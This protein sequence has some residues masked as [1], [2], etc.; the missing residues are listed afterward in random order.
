MM[1]KIMKFISSSADKIMKLFF[2][3]KDKIM[4]LYA[5]NK[6]KIMELVSSMYFKIAAGILCVL[7]VV[8][9]VCCSGGKKAEEE[10]PTEP[11]EI[12]TEA[13]TEEPTE[14]PTEP[15][16]VTV[17][18][19]TITAGKLNVRKDAGSE[20]EVVGSY[21]N[22]DRV[23]ILET[24]TVGDTVWG[25]TN[26]GWVGMGYVRM[27][28]TAVPETEQDGE[29]DSNTIIS[30][31]SIRVLAYGVVDLG[32]LNVRLGPGTEYGKA[33]TVAEGTR[34]AVYQTTNGWARIELGWVSTEYFYIE[35]TSA[36][37]A[38]TGIVTTDDLNIRTGPATSF[39]STGTC[40]QGET[41]KVLG[42]VGSWGYT[43]K[44]WISMTYVEPSYTTGTG[45]VTSGLNIRKEP[46]ADSEAVG[47]YKA[48]DAVTI[49]EVQGSWGKTDQ[50]WINLAYV[51]YD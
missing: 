29:S 7:L 41:V 25:R 28:G 5:A 15:V 8:G 34:Y 27:D 24:K 40:Q 37:D 45:K 30:D 38:M 12:V 1:D 32:E 47:T 35:G 48:G 43:E 23:E 2:A 26:L 49:I 20:H 13:A 44:G 50:G 19:G 17:N 42:Q 46:N 33:G 11:T 21:L 39:R 36:D 4:D 31:G 14:A 22:G 16:T 9:L 18:M 6:D 51:K 3:G 10:V